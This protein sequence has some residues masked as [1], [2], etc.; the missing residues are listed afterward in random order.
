MKGEEHAANNKI[1]LMK[2]AFKNIV[3]LLI[4]YK[5]YI[6][7]LVLILH[8]TALDCIRMQIPVKDA[9]SDKMAFRK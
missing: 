5:I 7:Y 8:A 2:I 4:N 1:G 9:L 3:N 6:F